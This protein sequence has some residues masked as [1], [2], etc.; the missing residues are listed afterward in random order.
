M[1]AISGKKDIGKLFENAVFLELKRRLPKNVKINYWRNKQGSEVDFVI[2]EGLKTKEIIQVCYDIT[3]EKT[4]SREIK[5]I[6]ACSKELKSGRGLIITKELE[7]EKT[8]EGIKIK[9]IPL[10]KWLLEDKKF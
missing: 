4:K 2:K 7:E 8:F 6:V 5:G 3:G 1:Y 10:W 9:Y